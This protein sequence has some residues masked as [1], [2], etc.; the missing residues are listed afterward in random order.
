MEQDIERLLV[1]RVKEIGGIAYKFI[2]PGHAGV[3]DRLIIV[4]GGEIV[5]V[6]LKDRGKKERALQKIAQAEL[7]E[8]GAKVFSAVDS[9]DKVEEVIR[10][11]RRVSDGV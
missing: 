8:R 10:Y 11:L 4:P 6:E 9:A 7:R 1:R 3:P 2:S 5:F